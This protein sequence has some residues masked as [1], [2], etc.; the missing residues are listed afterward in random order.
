MSAFLYLAALVAALVGAV[1]YL[2]HRWASYARDCEA[3]ITRAHADELAAQTDREFNA[4]V[5][6]LDDDMCPN[7]V[8]P[9]KC[10]GPHELARLAPV[11]P[12]IAF[13]SQRQA[14]EQ[15]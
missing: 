12:V 9:W 13:P 3:C 6:N 8:T 5:F 10:N 15:S 11:A 2:D 14:G 4:A 7:C 1:V